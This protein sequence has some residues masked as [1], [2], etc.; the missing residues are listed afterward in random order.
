MK[1]KLLSVLSVSTLLLSVTACGDTESSM[2]ATQM[3]TGEETGLIEDGTLYVATSPSYPPFE[4]MEGNELAG[5]DIELIEA[6]GEAAGLDVEFGVLEF[7]N[8]ISGVQAGQYD[9]G[10]SAFSVTEER[11]EHVL[12]GTPYYYSAQVALVPADSTITTLA[13]IEGKKLGAGLGTTAEPAANL[14]SDDIELVNT[15]V[16]FPMLLNGQIDAYICDTGVAE[17]AVKTGKFKMIEEPIQEEEMAMVFKKD[18]QALADDLNES[19][20]E[21]METQEYQDLLEKYELS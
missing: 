9:V 7:D 5:F 10:V 16:G 21:F 6:V 4:Y 1:K 13:E 20:N 11:A 14:L 17:N 12:F 8:I 3:T 15:D 18:N 2:T 19:L